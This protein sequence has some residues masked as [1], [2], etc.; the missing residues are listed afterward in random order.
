MKDLGPAGYFRGQELIAAVV[1]PIS[2]DVKRNIKCVDGE[3][4]LGQSADGLPTRFANATGCLEIA[5][6]GN[7]RSAALRRWK[8][9]RRDREA[10]AS[11]ALNDRLDQ[12]RVDPQE[13]RGVFRVPAYELFHIRISLEIEILLG[14]RVFVPDELHQVCNHEG[15]RAPR[16]TGAGA[17]GKVLV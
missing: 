2:K 5:E 13:R 1:I 10:W 16:R 12:A 14:P 3:I 15:T 7:I 6:H 11:C 17:L 4:T 8:L 9:C